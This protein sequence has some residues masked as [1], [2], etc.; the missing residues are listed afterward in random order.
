MQ[1]TTTK[2][3]CFLLICLVIWC[4][5]KRDQLALNNSPVANAGKDTIVYDISMELNGSGSTDPENNIT[6]YFWRKIAGPFSYYI[7]DPRAVQTKVASLAEGVYQ[8]ELTVTDAAGLSSRDTVSVSVLHGEIIFNLAWT[9]DAAN[10][11]LFMQSPELP[12]AYPPARI[13]MVYLYRNGF[14]APFGVTVYGSWFP[15]QKDGTSLGTFS[16]KIVNNTIMAY[17]Y[18]DF[19]D[20]SF[21]FVANQL[22]LVFR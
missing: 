20:V 10:K 6:S 12:A 2:T 8:F 22:R 18:Y 14:T 13:N 3:T 15:I 1:H 5:N 9:N 7:D 19:Y 16:Y 21:Y 17:V 4:C 11:I